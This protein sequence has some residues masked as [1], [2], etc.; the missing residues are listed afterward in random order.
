MKKL[1]A[2][3]LAALMMVAAFAGCGGSDDKK[4]DAK[5]SV[6]LADVI[7]EVNDEFSDATKGLSA[8]ADEAEL[9]KVYSIDEADVAQFAG[10]INKDASTAPVE[11]VVV[12]AKDSA[13]L[14]NVKT[15]LEN[16]FNS[17]LSQ[18][19]SYS[20]EEYEMAKDCAVTTTGNFAVLIV[21]EDYDDI[22]KTI[23]DELK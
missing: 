13:S 23:N 15:K 21:A 11:I 1:I 2:A 16:R 7:S 20:P 14:K 17:I 18:Y 19:S 9:K 12:E 4:D 6:K 8:I 22:L 5:E 3:A 10:E